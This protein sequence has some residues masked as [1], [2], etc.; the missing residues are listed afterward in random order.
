VTSGNFGQ[1]TSTQ[2]WRIFEL[3]AK[4]MF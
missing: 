3:G 4:L 2:P 1:L